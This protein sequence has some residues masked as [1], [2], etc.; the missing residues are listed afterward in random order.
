MSRSQ[1][2]KKAT[3]TIRSKPFWLGI[4]FVIVMWAFGV[5]GFLIGSAFK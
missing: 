5:L 4:A 3:N 2:T 1:A